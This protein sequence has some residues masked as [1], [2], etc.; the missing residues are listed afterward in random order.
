MSSTRHA[1]TESGVGPVL[2]VTP[3]WTRTG[4]VA[5][6]SMA[7]ATALA[8]HGV[9][10]NVAA[11][12]VDDAVNIPGVNVIHSPDLFNA[13]ALPDDRVGEAMGTEPFVVHAHQFEDPEVVRFMQTRAP[14]LISA[15]GYTAC[16]SGLHYFRPG[17]EC[18]RAH[19]PGC[20]ANLVLRG[21]AHTHHVRSWPKGYRRVGRAVQALRSADLAVSYSSAVDRHLAANGVTRRS[22]IPLFATMVPPAG[23]GHATRRRVV[24]A[25]RVVAPKGVGVLLRAAREVDAEFVICGDG[26]GWE[27][28]RKLARRLGVQ[29]RVQF[30]GWLSAEQL[31]LELAEASVVAMPSVWPE[32]F[33]L[34]GIEA[35]AA[36]RPVVASMTG[37]VTDWLQDG[38]NGRGVK[39]G[40]ARELAGALNE[41]LADPARQHA[42]GAA[43]RRLASARFSAEHH[44]AALIA[45]Y[46]DARE[47]WESRSHS[48]ATTEASG[49]VA[50]ALAG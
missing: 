8:E 22:V 41:L 37:G 38:V 36:G 35:F 32:P 42:M 33:G 11:A 7:S 24:F 34:V 13:E 12:R 3:V 16:T 6:H 28:M 29:E 10:V 20:L 48:T 17:E 39:P 21:C 5:T 26:F 46:R 31:A 25:G 18:P 1:Q 40:D 14:V 50:P 27:A 4:G 44:V 47:T 9:Q 43:G 49:H 15:H 19:G 2:L 45:A 23:S 30:K